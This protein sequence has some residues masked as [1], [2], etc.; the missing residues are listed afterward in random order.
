MRRY[1]IR[2]VAQ[3]ALVLWALT[4]ILFVLFRLLPGD[5]LTVYVDVGLPSDIQAQIL[6]QFGLDQPLWK[7]YVLYLAN[8]LRGDFGI[9]FHYRQ[10]VTEII[11]DKF[12][13]TMLLMSA[14]IFVTYA[15]GI[16]LGAFLGWRRGSRT[17]PA[18]IAGV[19]VFKAAPVFWTGML[20]IG[21][22]S[23]TLGWFPLGGMRAVGQNPQTWAEEYLTLEFLHHLVLPTLV[24]AL[25]HIGTPLLL[26]RSTLLE[27]LDEDYVELARAKGLTERAVLYRH[28]VRNALLPVTT[29]LAISLGSALGGQVLIEVIFRWPGMGREIVQAVSTS[30]YPLSQALFFTMGLM[31]I[32]MNLVADL[33]YGYLDPRI[34][35][36]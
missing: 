3:S 31:T 14:I 20:A 21:L 15:V 8:A 2:R 19:L 25:Y 4:T 32:A 13:P 9:S 10:P 29:A 1:I 22:F 34:V 18:V 28:A 5:P 17:E 30:D 27:V 23:I 16:L 24:G 7:Q 11:A 12:W 35:Y 26:M 33:A 36:E 6:R